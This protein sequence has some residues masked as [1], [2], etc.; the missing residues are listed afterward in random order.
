MGGT[1][2]FAESAFIIDLRGWQMPMTQELL[3]QNHSGLTSLLPRLIGWQRATLL[4]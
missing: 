3:H 4:C 2:C 1:I